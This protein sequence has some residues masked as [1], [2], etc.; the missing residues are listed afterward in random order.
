[1]STRGAPHQADEA[2]CAAHE[3][4][5]ERLERAERADSWVVHRER[6]A[7][8]ACRRRAGSAIFR[9]IGTRDIFLCRRCYPLSPSKH[10]HLDG[11]IAASLP[12]RKEHGK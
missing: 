5:E 6:H 10:G 4:A 11:A 8:S 1:M 12:Q 2:A 7:C 9:L 3:T